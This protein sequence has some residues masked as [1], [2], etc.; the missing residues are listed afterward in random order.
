[1]FLEWAQPLSHDAHNLTQLTVTFRN[2]VKKIHCSIPMGLIF[3]KALP[4][5][6]PPTLPCLSPAGAGTLFFL[7]Q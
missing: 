6:R 2:K 5:S 3:H 7:L 1:M 4:L